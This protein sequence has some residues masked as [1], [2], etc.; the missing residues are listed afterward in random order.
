[1]MGPVGSVLKHTPV[2]VLTIKR[3]IL[4]LVVM[5]VRTVLEN[6][7]IVVLTIEGMILVVV[8]EVVPVHVV[9]VY[10]MVERILFFVVALVPHLVLFLDI[11]L[12]GLD[13]D[14]HLLRDP[15]QVLVHVLTPVLGPLLDA[16]LPRPHTRAFL[17]LLLAKALAVALIRLDLDI[18]TDFLFVLLF[19]LNLP[20]FVVA[21]KPEDAEVALEH[22][23]DLL[24]ERLLVLLVGETVLVGTAPNTMLV[25][26]PEPSVVVLLLAGGGRRI[27]SKLPLHVRVRPALV[28][29]ALHTL[30]ASV[31]HV[32]PEKAAFVV[33]PRQLQ[34][35]PPLIF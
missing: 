7:A 27:R 30:S 16:V 3:M 10:L 5:V 1:M 22:V 28:D 25:V 24:S 32:V 20:G 34:Q 21:P 19:L 29:L 8:I 9:V 31:D 4:V 15:V 2:V 26:L 17:D 11:F 13:V 12:V 14:L 33:L 6:A 23:E 18:E 35:T